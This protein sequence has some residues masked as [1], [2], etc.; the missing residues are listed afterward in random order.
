[1]HIC[2]SHVF[3]NLK[4]MFGILGGHRLQANLLTDIDGELVH[5]QHPDF[6][7]EVT[8]RAQEV[9]FSVKNDTPA[10]VMLA[11]GWY[12]ATLPRTFENA[13]EQIYR[14]IGDFTIVEN[15]LEACILFP[16][17]DEAQI[18]RIK[19]GHSYVATFDSG[20]NQLKMASFNTLEDYF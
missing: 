2:I 9:E 6:P 19:P 17:V 15:R 11:L 1:M 10:A 20:T 14:G 12:L 7:I 5:P 3:H 13:A 18:E 4:A 8:L 16:N